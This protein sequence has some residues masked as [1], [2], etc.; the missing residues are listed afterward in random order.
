[1]PR[2]DSLIEMLNNKAGQSPNNRTDAKVDLAIPMGKA[3]V[4]FPDRLLD[5][6]FQRQPPDGPLGAKPPN[7]PPGAE[8]P[9][10]PP[11]A[12]PPDGP[13]DEARQ[14]LRNAYR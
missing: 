8:Q 13:L 11:G 5:K 14:W 7:G 6:P 10:G 1:M 12:E 4:T 9:N 3:E 2:M